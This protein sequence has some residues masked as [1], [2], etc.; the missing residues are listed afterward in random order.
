[1]YGVHSIVVEG[2]G[3][4][5]TQGEIFLPHEGGLP[6]VVSEPPGISMPLI[7]R[8]LNLPGITNLRGNRTGR[9]VPLLTGALGA[10]TMAV[11]AHITYR[12]RLDEVGDFAADRAEDERYARNAW[13]TYGAAVWGISAVDYW[14]RPRISLVETTPTRLTLGV[15]KAT[16]VGA[17]WRSILVPGAG[18]EY[19]N[20]YTRSIVWLTSVLGAGA[21][22][23][24]ADYRVRRD[25]TDLK[26]AQVNADSA[27][28]STA[29]QRQEELEQAQ[30]SLNASKDIRTGFL[31]GIAAF[32]A[33]NI[34]DAMIM[35]ITLP[36]PEKPK[37]SSISPIML[38]DG[39]G[40]GATFRF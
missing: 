38:P 32:H 31:I 6:F 26:W 14:I 20:H 22:Y 3:I 40:I 25:E 18:Q 39:P 9:G 17:V 2:L 24:V 29:V 7:L 1:M 34:A 19:G 27:G 30:R 35:Y 12:A 11:R 21:G 23:V 37:V 13:L 16:R 15:P 36:A 28:P 4:A 8:G 10:G 5:R 33:L